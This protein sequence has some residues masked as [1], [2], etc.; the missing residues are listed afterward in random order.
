MTTVKYTTTEN[1]FESKIKGAVPW[2]T[3]APFS[4]CILIY[5]AYELYRFILTM[6]KF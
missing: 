6:T 2:K 4:K 1:S 5:Q 3:P